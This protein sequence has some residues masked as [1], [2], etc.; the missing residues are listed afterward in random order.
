MKYGAFFRPIARL[1]CWAKL[2]HDWRVLRCAPAHHLMHLH[3]HAGQ[4]CVCRTCGLKWLDYD[5]YRS[6]HRKMFFK[7]GVP[8]PVP[9]LACVDVHD[10]TPSDPHS[11]R[12]NA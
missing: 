12:H 8:E 11:Y 7:M 6:V 9:C 4:D 2:G 1:L 10:V 3:A 5:S